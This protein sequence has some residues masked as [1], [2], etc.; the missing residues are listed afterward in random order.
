MDGRTTYD[1]NTA[2]ALRASR[3]KRCTHVQVD[4]TVNLPFKQ[5]PPSDFRHSQVCGGALH[6]CPLEHA[7]EHIA[8]HTHTRR[9]MFQ[10]LS[11]SHFHD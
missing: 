11:Q 6:T 2:L 1:S 3:G 8:A 7:G 4:N 9:R 5:A 10:L